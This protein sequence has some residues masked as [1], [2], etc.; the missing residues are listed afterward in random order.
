LNQ[1][2][3]LITQLTKM[4]KPKRHISPAVQKLQQN[5][6]KAAFEKTKKRMMLAAKIQDAIKAKNISYKAFA[7]LMDQHDSVIS[8][9]VSGTHN[10]TT[11]TLFDIEDK[12][13]ICLV[14]ITEQPSVVTKK[15]ITIVKTSDSVKWDGIPGK[16]VTKLNSEGNIL[17]TA[18][19]LES[20][21][22]IGLP[23]FNHSNHEC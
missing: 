2:Q 17:I 4:N 19:P 23:I 16:G 21:K 18:S 7:E 14:S 13:G 22:H 10:F 5:R 1:I 3:T 9:W 12:L 20:H 11:D 8:K 15:Y 6:S